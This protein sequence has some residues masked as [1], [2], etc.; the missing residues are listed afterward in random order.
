MDKENLEWKLIE[1]KEVFKTVVFTVTERLSEAPDGSR[2]TYIVNEAR[3]WVIVIA[4]H[5]DKFLMVKQWRHG[6]MGL[7]IEFP[8]GVI[9]SGEDPETAARR[10]LLEETGCIAG[11]LQCLGS[12][13][14]N[15]ALFS[16][17][18]HVYL[19]TDLTFTGKQDLDQDEFVKYM[20]IDRKEVL[21]KIGCNEYP[22]ALMAS[23]AALYLTKDY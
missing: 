21:K 18:V 5:G 10:E 20:E 4:E 7:S 9:D 6:Q 17:R 3:D 23:A 14:P 2:G 19:A 22:H 1:R 13:N 16:N 15:P 11:K 12:M 8:G